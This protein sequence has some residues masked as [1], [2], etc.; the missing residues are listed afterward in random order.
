M[1]KGFFITGTGTE[2][3]KTIFTA[4]LTCWLKNNG[5]NVIPMKPIQTG[6][7]KTLNG[8]IAPD[9]DYVLKIADIVP[10]ERELGKMQP[11]CYE[12][13]CSPHLAGNLAGEKYPNIQIIKKNLIDLQQK[14]DIVLVEGAGGIFVP[15]DQKLTMLDLMQELDLP[16]I[17]VA[18]S[19]LGTLNHTLLSVFALKSRGIKMA[20]FVLNDITPVSEEDKYIREDN[21]KTLIEFSKEHYLGTL[22]YIPE[23]TRGNLI[24]VFKKDFEKG[25]R[26]ALKI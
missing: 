20:G 4:G 3:G 23:L 21:V 16:V 7:Q 14:H 10:P 26:E 19:S 17:L 12:T 1:V 8:W 11:F 2:V 22:S 5:L 6:A 24:N 13:A 25:I 15:I 18:N 9:L